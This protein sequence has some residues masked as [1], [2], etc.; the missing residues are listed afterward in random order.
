VDPTRRSRL[1]DVV[2]QYIPAHCRR[3][4]RV[5][6][7]DATRHWSRF[8]GEMYDRILLDAPC[9]SDR[10]VVAAAVAQGG[11]VPLGAWSLARCHQ[12]AKLQ[13][14]VRDVYCYAR[15]TAVTCVLPCWGLWHFCYGMS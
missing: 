10:H 11:K 8:E 15:C 9:S 13:T 14:Q 5:T 3:R 1:Q 2:Q 7:H 4:V 12:L 6:G